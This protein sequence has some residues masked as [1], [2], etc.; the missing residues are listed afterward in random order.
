MRVVCRHVGTPGAAGGIA[1]ILFAWLDVTVID[2]KF[3]GS[4]VAYF[5]AIIAHIATAR[6]PFQTS[7]Q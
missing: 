4:I 1:G 5:C 3:A 7:Q 6:H 2:T